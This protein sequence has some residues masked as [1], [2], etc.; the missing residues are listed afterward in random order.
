MPASSPVTWSSYATKE[1][2]SVKRFPADTPLCLTVWV[3][4]CVRDSFL[5]FFFF[6]AGLGLR[7]RVAFSLAA[8]SEATRSARCSGFSS[9]WLPL[10]WSEACELSTCGSRGLEHRLGGCG[11]RVFPDQ[12]S[13]LCLLH[14]QVDALPLSYQ[15]SLLVSP[16]EM[17]A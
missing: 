12:G 13:N 15:G 5:H 17:W 16:S 10:L 6:L 4:V 9:L 1:V 8:V 11:A 14:W 3:C 7:C 2:V